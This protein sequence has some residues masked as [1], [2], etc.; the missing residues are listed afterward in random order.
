MQE[1]TAIVKDLVSKIVPA[2]STGLLDDA[3]SI[4]TERSE[5]LGLSTED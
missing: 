2:P 1:M 4:I 5:D 3:M